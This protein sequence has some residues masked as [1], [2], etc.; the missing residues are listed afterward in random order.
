MKNICLI[1]IALLAVSTEAFLG[2]NVKNKDLI[3]KECLSFGDIRVKCEAEA[4]TDESTQEIAI[5]ATCCNIKFTMEDPKLIKDFKPDCCFAVE[6]GSFDF[7]D[8]V[9]VKKCAEKLHYNGNGGICND[10]QSA[11]QNARWICETSSLNRITRTVDKVMVAFEW[12]YWIVL[13]LG[14]A[15]V[16]FAVSKFGVLATLVPTRAKAVICFNWVHA[17]EPTALFIWITL[18][19]AGEY[20]AGVGFLWGLVVTPVVVLLSAVMWRGAASFFLPVTV[21]A[22]R[23]VRAPTHLPVTLAP[24]REPTASEVVA[25]FRESV[26]N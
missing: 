26:R 1:L 5:R 17:N 9:A 19:I 6:D 25:K 24:K 16:L 20:F 14:G 3:V 8:R 12:L 18:V 10:W 22:K 21:P 23:A 4:F 15:L 7:S 13:A 11:E 2:F